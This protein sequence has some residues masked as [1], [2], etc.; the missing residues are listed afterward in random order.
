M[1]GSG[2]IRFTEKDA[3]R[4]SQTIRNFNA[5]IDRI[6]KRDPAAA[7]YLPQKQ[8]VR[9]IKNEIKSGHVARADFNRE[10]K[11][12]TRFSR[13]GVEAAIKSETGLVMTKWEKRET[14]IKVNIINARRRREANAIQ[15]RPTFGA[16]NKTDLKNLAPKPFDTNSIQPGREW[17]MYVDSV[18]KQVSS[19]YLLE[20][21]QA[22]K[23]KYLKAIARQ[24]GLS[25]KALYEYVSQLDPKEISDAMYEDPLL[26]IEYAYDPAAADIIADATMEKWM[27]FAPNPDGMEFNFSNQEYNEIMNEAAKRE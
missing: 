24:L 27:E 23:D 22:Y 3:A 11:S 2:K 4:L 10:I 6:A 13:K 26:K 7:A 14:Q 15:S 9:A 18:E 25:G 8:S 20:Q 16:H 5:K 17:R 21:Q 1:P 12:M 19:R